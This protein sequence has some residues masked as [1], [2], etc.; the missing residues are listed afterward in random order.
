MKSAFAVAPKGAFLSPIMDRVETMCDWNGKPY[1]A[2]GKFPTGKKLFFRIWYKPTYPGCTCLCFKLLVGREQD[3]PLRANSYFISGSFDIMAN[4]W[5][6]FSVIRLCR[7]LGFTLAFYDKLPELFPDVVLESEHDFGC[8]FDALVTRALEDVEAPAQSEHPGCKLEMRDV[9]N[10]VKHL[11]TGTY[12]RLKT[13]PGKP[14]VEAVA[15]LVPTNSPK[16]TV[17]AWV[18]P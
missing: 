17:S 6:T 18:S 1:Y 8:I 3:K 13:N 9:N 11:V 5:S 2:I 7:K 16:L 4:A 14:V 15:P 12:V 10:D